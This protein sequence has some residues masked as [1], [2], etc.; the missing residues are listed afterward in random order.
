MVYTVHDDYYYFDGHNIGTETDVQTTPYSSVFSRGNQVIILWKIQEVVGGRCGP[1][2]GH[3]Y[4]MCFLPT[5]F[6]LFCSFL[7]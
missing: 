2:L 7:L 6:F 1:E 4:R 5:L 3:G